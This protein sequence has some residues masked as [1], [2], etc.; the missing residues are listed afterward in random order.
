MNHMPALI[1]A[2]LP[3]L[4]YALFT[5]NNLSSVFFFPE[6]IST[7]RIGFFPYLIVSLAVNKMQQ[8]EPNYQLCFPMFS[9]ALAKNLFDL[10]LR[11]A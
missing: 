8:R 1:T 11:D 6:Q 10:F 3:S 9:K 4:K 5:G 7:D 2:I